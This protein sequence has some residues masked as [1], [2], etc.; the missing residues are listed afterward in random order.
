MGG[1][2][3]TD[4]LGAFFAVAALYVLVR[5]RSAAVDFV[6]ALSG[7]LVALVRRATDLEQQR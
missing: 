7:A 3:R 2:G 5:P 4:V 6:Q 1:F